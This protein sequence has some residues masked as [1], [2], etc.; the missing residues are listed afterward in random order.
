MSFSDL[1]TFLRELHSNRES[2]GAIAPSSPLLG[3][4]LCKFISTAEG[5]KTILEVG[6]GTGTITEQIIECLHPGDSLHLVEL[7]PKFCDLLNELSHSKWANSLQGVDFRVYCCS[8]EDFPENQTYQ[9]LVS[10][11]PLNNFDFDLVKSILHSYRELLEPGGKLSYF[12]YLAARKMREVLSKVKGDDDGLR[13]CHLLREFIENFQL[14][15]DEVI[16][17]FPPAV[18]RHFSFQPTDLNQIDVN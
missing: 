8:M 13:T 2:V 14:E 12:E 7:N 5:S 3:R 9:F 6:P 18:A 1:W 17:N 11:L 16:M 4:S 15:Y 10:S